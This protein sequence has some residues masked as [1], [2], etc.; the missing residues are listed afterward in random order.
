[1]VYPR[2]W[3]I[4]MAASVNPAKASREAVAMLN[5]RIPEKSFSKAELRKA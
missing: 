5:G 4:F 2:V 1:L 3:G